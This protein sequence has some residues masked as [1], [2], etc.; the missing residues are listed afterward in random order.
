MEWEPQQ[1]D[2]GGL[3]FAGI[4][5]EIHRVA[6]R[7]VLPNTEAVTGGAAILTAFLLAHLTAYSAIISGLV[8]GHGV[9][10][11]ACLAALILSEPTFMCVLLLLSFVC[12]AVCVLRVASLYCTDG[13]SDATDRILRDIPRAPVARLARMFKDVFLLAMAYIVFSV[14]PLFLLLQLHGSH[15]EVLLLLPL[16]VLGGAA[17]LASAAYVAVVSH[18]ACVVAMLEDAVDFGAMRK[19]RALLAGK[20]WQAAAVFVPLDACFLALQT[21]FT[22]LVFDDALGLGLWFK[23]AAGA[24]MAVAL[25][26]VVVATLVAQPVVYIV[27][28]NHQRRGRRQSPPPLRGRLPAAHRRRRQRRGA[29]AGLIR[30][31]SLQFRSSPASS[32]TST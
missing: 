14:I 11:V 18:I 15:G 29:A 16:K 28:K 12:T 3:G 2:L 27:C 19:S 9:R 20:L 26:A 17:C 10:F 23:L 32:S 21:F 22:V 30:R 25:W 6:L 8:E 31:R 7:A 4:C 24:A 5:R 13:D 1:Q